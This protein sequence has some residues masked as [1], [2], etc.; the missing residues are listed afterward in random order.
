MSNKK[1]K[2]QK[3]EFACEHAMCTMR[4]H[5]S[6]ALQTCLDHEAAIKHSH[7][8]RYAAAIGAALED[9]AVP[10]LVVHA[11]PCGQPAASVAVQQRHDQ[12]RRV[13]ALLGRRPGHANV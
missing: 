12:R 2:Q 8:A 1:N 11:L 10:K 6:T 4:S 9:L 3:A 13:L 5:G 7:H